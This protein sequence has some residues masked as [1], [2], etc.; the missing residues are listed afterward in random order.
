MLGCNESGCGL[1]RC[2]MLGSCVRVS[3]ASPKAAMMSVM[4]REKFSAASRWRSSRRGRPRPRSKYLRAQ[5][6]HKVLPYP[7]QHARFP[8]CNGAVLVI[9][10]RS[11]GSTDSG[12][13]YSSG[14]SAVQFLKN[15][16]RRRDA[17]HPK[18]LTM[19]SMAPRS[20]PPAARPTRF[21]NTLCQWR[22]STSSRSDPDQGGGLGTG[23]RG[24]WMVRTVTPAAA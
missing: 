14:G 6:G 3:R 20:S 10:A 9:C 11:I 7:R 21:S 15:A 18:S 4:R 8:T 19:A 5:P 17:A 2:G 1:G 16:R 13:C 12:S 23:G 24:R 22:L